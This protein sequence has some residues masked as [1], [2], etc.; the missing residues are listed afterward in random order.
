MDS[1]I[2]HVDCFGLLLFQS[3][4]DKP[5]DGHIVGKDGR[6]C[7]I[8][9]LNGETNIALVTSVNRG[10]TVFF[11]EDTDKIFHTGFVCI[12]YTKVVHNKGEHEIA[13]DVVFSKARSN[14][15]EQS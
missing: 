4:I 13:V 11:V 2:L 12:A 1:I 9:P 7:I 5:I 15:A 10:F 6:L 3:I 8:A 14:G